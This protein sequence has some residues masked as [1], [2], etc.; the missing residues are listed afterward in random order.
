MLLWHTLSWV[1]AYLALF[2]QSLLLL[3]L[4]VCT[5]IVGLAKYNSVNVCSV[6]LHRGKSRPGRHIGFGFTSSRG[7]KQCVGPEPFWKLDESWNSSYCCLPTLLHACTSTRRLLAWRCIWV[8]PCCVQNDMGMGELTNVSLA[9][10]GPAGKS[11]RF[12]HLSL[13]THGLKL[14]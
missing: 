1:T 11:L 4:Q 12:A 3:I 9:G 6:F 10:T 7:R 8:S 14:A 13:L 2:D 5:N